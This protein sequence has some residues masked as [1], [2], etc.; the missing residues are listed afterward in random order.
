MSP[1]L[2]VATVLLALLPAM[3]AG[4][5]EFRSVEV[6]ETAL[7]EE[8]S[9]LGRPVVMLEYGARIEVLATE[10]GWVRGRVE[11]D[12]R[13]GW[14]GSSALT[15]DRII[16][17][18]DGEDAARAA[19]DTEVALAGRGFNADVEARYRREQGLDFEAID[20]IEAR[21]VPTAELADFITS[22]GLNHPDGG[23]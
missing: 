14:V 22:A 15:A 17:E 10:E 5:E 18:A 11:D 20:R 23:E 2:V 3:S 4:A 9:Y 1:R 21:G 8:P 19:D 7:R 12:G 16:L 6:G 13:E